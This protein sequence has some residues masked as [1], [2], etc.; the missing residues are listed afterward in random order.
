MGTFTNENP[1]PLDPSGWQLTFSD[2]FDGA[3][4]DRAAWPI[5]FNGSRYWNNAFE[6]RAENVIVWDGELTVSSIASP[7]GWTAG[8]VNMGW[9]GQ[10]YG[11]WEVRARLDEG[12]GTSAAILLWP[13][14]GEYP[15]EI[16]LMESPDPG[17]TIT[18]MTVH[19]EGFADAQGH[20][21]FSD[22][23]EWHTYAVDWLP[24]RITFYIDGVERWST[25]K[26]V[27]DE[28][29]ALGFMSFVAASGDEWF[30]GAPDASTPGLVSL[31]VDWA[32]IWTPD[33]LHPGEAP[34][35]QYR[36]GAT[37]SAAP[38][39]VDTGVR[40]LDGERYAASWNR[41]EWGAVGGV[42]LDSAL[43]WV[44]GTASRLLFANFEEAHLALDDAPMG[45]EVKVIGAATGVMITGNGAD[46]V[47][48]LAHADSASRQMPTGIALRGGDDTLL[49]TTPA[50][51]SLWQPFA[52]GGRWNADYDGRLS[53]IHASGNEGNDRIEVQ[54]QVL[55]VAHGGTGNDTLIGGGGADTLRG[56]EDA[57]ELTGG[58]GRDTFFWQPGEG[59]DVMRDF[60]P[61]VDRLALSD[62][63]PALVT[64]QAAAGG[65]SV[66][67][68][69]EVLAVLQGVT[70]LQPGDMVFG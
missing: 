4:L 60:A 14:D 8:G 55:L 39:Q 56:A 57:D 29:M 20:Q 38:D 13:T 11:R 17:R 5:L 64:T 37:W 22:A 46:D 67:Y 51:S 61:G 70:A 35:L 25:T 48:W 18:S 58:G 42:W 15:P 30:G 45:L 10:L 24:G 63:D 62:M 9:N 69:G 32:R 16:D 23:S 41:A 31:H 52:W 21:V 49:V 50:T 40:S 28:P 34:P 19:S 7:S 47:T 53:R 12:K 66:A 65:L 44:P 3:Y 1:T 68:R 27:P 6:W 54:A 43:S 33:E 26:G 2:G 36:E 59:G